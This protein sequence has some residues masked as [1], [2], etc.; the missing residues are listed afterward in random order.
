MT[1]GELKKSI[2]GFGIGV[3]SSISEAISGASGETTENE[4]FISIVNRSA[5]EINRILPARGMVKL[6]H[7][8]NTSDDAMP[9]D[10][11]D[12]SALANDFICL[13][14]MSVDHAD[15]IR[16]GIGFMDASHIRVKNE[17][18]TAH[19]TYRRK[20]TELTV[21][22]EDSEVIDLRDDL[23]DILPMLVASYLYINEDR[24]VASYYRQLY[25]ARY[26]DLY[27]STRNIRDEK[28]ISINNWG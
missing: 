5:S 2:D 8:K 17:P 26:N 15:V 13:D 23:A 24:S 19:I 28:P 20:L 6:I 22:S 21:D 10:V 11:V 9:Y 7:E 4:R 25:D 3:D 18:F 14:G 12:I 1:L 16:C 27:H